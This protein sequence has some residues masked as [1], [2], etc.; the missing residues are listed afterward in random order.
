MKLL[1]LASLLLLFLSVACGPTPPTNNQTNSDTT[2]SI[3]ETT[4]IGE[5]D[6]VEEGNEVTLFVAPELAECTEAG[7]QTC[8]MVKEKRED[9]YTYFYDQIDDFEYEEGYEYELRVLVVPVDAS[10]LNYDLL[11]V[12]SKTA[13]STTN[14]ETAGDS[15]ASFED[16][17]WQLDS[18]RANGELIATTESG[19]YTFTSANSETPAQMDAHTGCNNISA[20]YTLDEN[21]ITFGM[22][23]S[24]QKSCS[25]AMSAQEAGIQSGLYSTISYAVDGD[26]L[27]M[28]DAT[29]TVMMQFSAVDD[30]PLTDTLWQA[31][32]LNDGTG[33]VISVLPETTVT[34]VFNTDNTLSGNASCNIYNTTY[35]ADGNNLQVDPSIITTRRACVE[36]ITAQEGM[37]L[38]ALSNSVMSKIAGNKLEL[39]DA[40]GGLM[41][42]YTAVSAQSL[43]GITWEAIAYNSGGQ[44]MVGV[45]DG[46]RITAVFDKEGT[47]NGNA[48]CNTYFSSYDIDDNAINIGEEVARTAMDCPD[49]RVM[50]QE[51]AYLTALLTAVTYSISDNK[52][53][54]HTADGVLA[55]S[56][57]A[58]E[59]APL[60]NSE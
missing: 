11:E 17:M 8:M 19:A 35:Q 45:L 22:G 34:A 23:I 57:S 28:T 15:A 60:S 25:E 2:T 48:G 29:G 12:V 41:L 46:A 18:Y 54:L 52:L 56:Y 24:T 20:T 21:D 47:I 43:T 30:E 6:P 27:I 39:R 37:Y 40:D 53:E 32:S 3:D 13:V 10:M 5:Y 44:A 58:A 50:T 49:D 4:L 55:A 36:P 7:A 42:S 59:P 31:T 1:T 14:A 16:N 9:E 26:N 51:S 38:T 33:G